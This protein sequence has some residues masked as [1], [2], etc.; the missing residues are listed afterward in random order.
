MCNPLFIAMGFTALSGLST[1]KSQRDMGRA[2]N[3]V[4]KQNAAAVENQAKDAASRG[5]VAEERHRMQVRQFMGRQRAA[6]AAGGLQLDSGTPLDLQT[7]TARMGELDALMIRNNAA[8][9]AWGYRVKAQ[10]YLT[11]GKLDKAAGSNAAMGTLLSTGAS[12]FGMYAAGGLRPGGT[13]GG[14]NP[15]TGASAGVPQSQWDYFARP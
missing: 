14:Y 11:Q 4:A 2:Q 12:M 1:A 15:A 3:E 5:A 8:R 7:D 13:A 9:E 10:N 6:M